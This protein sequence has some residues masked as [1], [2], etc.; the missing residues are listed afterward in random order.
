MY[1]MCGTDAYWWRW[2]DHD[3]Q[4]P[5]SIYICRY[6][7]FCTTTPRRMPRR[8]WTSPCSCLWMACWILEEEKRYVCSWVSLCSHALYS[9]AHWRCESSHIPLYRIE[10]FTNREWQSRNERAPYLSMSESYSSL[11]PNENAEKSA[12]YNYPQKFNQ[13]HTWDLSL[14]RWSSEWVAQYPVSWPESRTF[15]A[16]RN[17]DQERGGKLSG[18]RA[19]QGLKPMEKNKRNRRDNLEADTGGMCVSCVGVYMCGKSKME[20]GIMKAKV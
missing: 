18:K 6:R 3:A 13:L 1:V 11:L 4:Q 2:S 20:L 7:T 17:S 14:S 19:C 15:K 16:I 8:A 10:Q 12:A 5:P 9:H